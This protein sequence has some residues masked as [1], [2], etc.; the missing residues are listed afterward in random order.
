[1]MSMDYLKVGWKYY[2]SLYRYSRSMDINYSIAS[3]IQRD[4]LLLGVDEAKQDEE[5]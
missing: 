3:K 4:L 5:K 1:M 2:Y